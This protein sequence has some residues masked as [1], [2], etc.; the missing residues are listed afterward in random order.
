MKD[1]KRLNKKKAEKRV[2]MIK[3][4]QIIHDLIKKKKKKAQLI[5][6]GKIVMD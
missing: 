3:K 6:T 2:Y 1:S 5:N 4:G